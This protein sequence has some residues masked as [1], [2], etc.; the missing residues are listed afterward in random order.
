MAA[1]HRRAATHAQRKQFFGDRAEDNL[2]CLC[3]FGFRTISAWRWSGFRI[4]RAELGDL[5]VGSFRLDC[6]R[7]RSRRPGVVRTRFGGAGDHPRSDRDGPA[8]HRRN[9]G[10][11]ACAGGAGGQVPHRVGREGQVPVRTRLSSEPVHRVG[12]HRRQD[13]RG[14][15]QQ[16]RPDLRGRTAARG[17][18][19]CCAGATGRAGGAFG[20]R[21]RGSAA[22]R[23]AEQPVRRRA[24]VEPQRRADWNARCRAEERPDR[25]AT[26]ATATACRADAAAGPDRPTGQADAQAQAGAAA[27]PRRCRTTDRGLID[28]GAAIATRT[29]P[30]PVP[31]APPPAPRAP[32]PLSDNGQP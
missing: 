19:R 20:G 18:R 27:S 32:L 10:A 3:N 4:S 6:R 14:G 28:R 21:E 5:S 17:G 16:L 9:Y 7:G 29:G 8:L 15:R 31:S 30:K 1:L 24:A 12:D 2:F 23:G 22:A 26:E 13:C 11:S 25:S